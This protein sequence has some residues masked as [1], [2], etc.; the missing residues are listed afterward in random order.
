MTIDIEEAE[1]ITATT[2]I[3]LRKLLENSPETVFG[4]NLCILYI[5]NL[6]AHRL[7]QFAM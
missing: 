5:N 3:R 7:L 2:T 1:R 4:L 6:I